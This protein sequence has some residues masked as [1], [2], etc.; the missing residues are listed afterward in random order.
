M[1]N[2]KRDELKTSNLRVTLPLWESSPALWAQT[3]PSITR[4]WPTK[5]SPNFYRKR[6]AKMGSF[7]FA[8]VVFARM[9]NARDLAVREIILN[10]TSDFARSILRCEIA[11]LD[12]SF[13]ISFKTNCSNKTQKNHSDES[14]KTVCKNKTAPVPFRKDALVTRLWSERTHLPHCTS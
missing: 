3:S 4:K 12:R 9:L 14:R 6:G 2:Q 10:Y 11:T 7:I 13:L 8:N 1:Q 5:L